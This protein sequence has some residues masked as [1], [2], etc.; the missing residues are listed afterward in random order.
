MI[1]VIA[2]AMV[3]GWVVPAITQ[4]DIQVR[5]QV[6]S[7]ALGVE[8]LHCHVA[9]QWTDA[10]KPTFEFARRM[11][12]MVDGLNAGPLKE[13]GQVTCWTCHRGNAYPRDCPAPRG[14]RYSLTT[15]QNSKDAR[16]VASR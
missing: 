2:L 13:V 5:M 16:T 3:V 6:W 11:M 14:R 12:R 7:K 1:A 9:G 8:C 10:A 4:D 15:K